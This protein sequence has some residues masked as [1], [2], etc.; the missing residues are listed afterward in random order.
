MKNALRSAIIAAVGPGVP[1]VW[2]VLPTPTLPA[3]IL[4]RISETAGISHSGESSLRD[5]VAQ[6]DC[7]AATYTAADDLWSAVHAAV[8]D[9]GGQLLGVS[10]DHERGANEATRPFR[11]SADYR[12]HYQYG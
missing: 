6:I 5:V 4:N 7:Y 12:I 3:V 2:G 8:R 1:V 10:D 9:F 11:A